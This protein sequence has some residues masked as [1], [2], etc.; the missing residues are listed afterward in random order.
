[1]SKIIRRGVNLASDMD[2]ACLISYK[3]NSFGEFIAYVD[4]DY[5]SDNDEDEGLND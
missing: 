3:V 4:D 1:M 5:G 2:E